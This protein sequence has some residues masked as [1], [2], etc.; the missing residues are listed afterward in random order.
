MVLCGVIWLSMG[1]GNS[2]DEM[3]ASVVPCVRSAR[4]VFGCEVSGRVSC[5]AAGLHP[6]EARFLPEEG[7]GPDDELSPISRC[8]ATCRLPGAVSRL[9]VPDTPAAAEQRAKTGTAAVPHETWDH[10]NGK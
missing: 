1:Q 5:D 3:R 10:A 4:D 7:S 2:F 6:K 8:S 9:A